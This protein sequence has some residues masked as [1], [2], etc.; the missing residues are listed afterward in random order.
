M[1]VDSLSVSKLSKRFGYSRALAGVD[2]TL[3]AGSLCALLGP[4]G[5]GKSTLLGILSTLVRPNGGTVAYSSGDHTVQPGDELRGMIGVLAHESFIYGDLTGYEN[6]IFYGRLYQI[7]D[8]RARAEVLLAEVGLD[9]AAA[10]RPAR[11]Y[12][13]GM[14][15]RLALARTLL[16][17]P[18]IL[19]LDEPFTGLDRAGAAALARTL[20]RVREDG[21]ISVVVTHDL[22]SIA[23]V[24]DHVVVLRRGKV[25]HE[26]CREAA[27]S[28]EEL[29]EIY[30]RFTD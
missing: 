1:Q 18:Q 17:D 25:A 28:Y 16:H 19:L 4:N 22:E 27:F 24:T 3:R 14:L 5:A 11:N 21:K 26:E 10:A 15:Q 9:A 29:K 7:A 6:L 2:L 8:P 30:H 20:A 13:R 23:G 12:S